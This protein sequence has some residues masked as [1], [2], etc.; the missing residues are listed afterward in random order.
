MP[1]THGA[2][3]M[4]ALIHEKILQNCSSHLVQ[5]QKVFILNVVVYLCVGIILTTRW[6]G[7]VIVLGEE[8]NYCNQCWWRTHWCLIMYIIVLML[9]CREI[10]QDRI[11]MLLLEVAP[12][13]ITSKTM[14]WH[15]WE[16]P[17]LR[18]VPLVPVE[19]VSSL[20][21]SRLLASDIRFAVFL[22]CVEPLAGLTI[23]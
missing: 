20:G 14:Y 15:F 22:V 5:I 2:T 10:I 11:P 19:D 16:L 3:S 18:P 1:G 17:W 7:L 6:G 12:P 9:L 13:V 8:D 21:P 23:S 4:A